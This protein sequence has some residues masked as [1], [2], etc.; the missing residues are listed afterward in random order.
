MIND[1][2]AVIE[3]TEQN[4]E[5]MIYEVRGERVMLDFDLARIYGYTTKAFNQQVKNNMEKFP[6]DF[7][8]QLTREEVEQ[9]SRCKNITL[10]KLGN[11]EAKSFDHKKSAIE[12]EDFERSKKLTPELW[13]TGRGGRSYLPYAFTE[14][15]IYMLMTVL[16]GELAVKQSITL[17]RLFEK[18][19]SYITSSNNLMSTNEIIGLVNKV[20]K[21]DRQIQLVNNKL[22]IVMDN[23]IDPS[24]YKQFLIMNG[25]KIEADIAYQS[26]YSLANHS[27]IIID[28]YIDIKTLHLLLS[29]KR[30]VEITIISDNV[31]RNPL[32]EEYI[33]EFMK[34]TGINLIMKQSN[35]LCHDRFIVIDY[36]TDKEK[37][38][39]CGSSS[40][41]AG[42][43]I[44]TIIEVEGR[45]IYHPLIDLYK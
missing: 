24:T 36:L 21:H 43:K 23:F 45:D 7:M 12:S 9:L 13:A 44:T 25:R 42:N 8:L 6:E 37:I 26:I 22:D 2:L 14:K 34:E 28:D 20:N 11:I 27:L 15:G 19:K 33:D 32:Q 5:S 1:E 35:N 30:S 39:L 38:Y 40:K 18:M 10:N 41:D 4:L 17:I 3:I 31:S 16:R 29:I